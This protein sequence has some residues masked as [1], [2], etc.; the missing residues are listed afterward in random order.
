MNVEDF[1]RQVSAAFQRIPPAARPDPGFPR[2]VE[3]AARRRQRRN[4]GLTAGAAGLAVLAFTGIAF[5]LP[6]NGDG[7]APAAPPPVDKNMGHLI[8]TPSVL[9]PEGGEVTLIAADPTR[10]DTTYGVN[11]TVDRWDDG[12][13]QFHGGFTSSPASW[14]GTGAIYPGEPNP[15]TRQIG[16]R[17]RDDGYGA[18]EWLTV[19]GLSAGWY[20]IGHG[21]MYGLLEVRPGAAKPPEMRPTGP[22][23]LVAARTVRP[24]QATDLRLDPTARGGGVPP[25]MRGQV[26]VEK[27]VGSGWVALTSVTARDRPGKTAYT[28]DFDVSLPALD[29]GVHRVT[30]DS[31]AGTVT[32]VFWVL[33]PP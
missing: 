19:T 7:N 17:V 6:R 26:L 11:G 22:A 25:G 5:T 9:P 20:R 12:T 2:K 15:P 3:R 23:F 30:R 1:E 27:L 21:T 31:T 28:S 33:P 32:G 29:P 16:L 24:G 8:V 13:W 4:R 14:G 18:L 10:S